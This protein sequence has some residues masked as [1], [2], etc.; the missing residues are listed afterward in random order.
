MKKAI[1]TIAII[2]GLCLST[3][4]TYAQK[5]GNSMPQAIYLDLGGPGGAYSLNYDINF[6]AAP[7]GFGVRAGLSYM[8]F[9]GV[10]LFTFPVMGNYLFGNGN[11]FFEVG[12]GAT[13]MKL[14]AEGDAL[15]IDG[16]GIV[17][18]MNIGYRY[19]PQDGGF[20]FRAGLSPMFGGFGFYPLWGYLSFG[21]SF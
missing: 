2:T 3:N 1:Y 9:G 4:T 6:D 13:Y 19:Q 11:H 16:S 8:S 18:T 7:G 14:S 17:G 20:L 10:G 12:L 5:T 21:Y 15:F